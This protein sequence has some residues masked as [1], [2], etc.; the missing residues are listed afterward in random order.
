[1]RPLRVTIS[2]VEKRFYIFYVCI[3]ILTY[4]VCNA[5]APYC[6]LWAAQFYDIFPHYLINGTI[7]GKKKRLNIKCVSWVSL[8]LLP[9]IF[10]I[11]RRNE[12]DMFKLQ[13]SHCDVTTYQPG[14]PYRTLHFTSPHSYV[15]P[16]AAYAVMLP[17]MMGMVNAR[18][19]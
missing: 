17:L 6:H 10:L 18:N 11:V 2:A 16:T 7:F 3:C 4:P 14:Q 12:R 9:E 15:I 8:R 13:L 5:C 1:L 19:M